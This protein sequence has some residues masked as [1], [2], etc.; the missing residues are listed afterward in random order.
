MTAGYLAR[1]FW[2]KHKRKKEEI[3]SSKEEFPIKKAVEQ[4]RKIYPEFFPTKL[5][6]KSHVEPKENEAI[7]L[8]EFPASGIMKKRTEEQPKPRRHSMQGSSTKFPLWS[9]GCQGFRKLFSVTKAREPVQKTQYCKGMRKLSHSVPI[10]AQG[11]SHE[12]KKEEQPDCE[13]TR[14]ELGL[15]YVFFRPNNNKF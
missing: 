10:L 14:A 5:E 8:D 1:T 7:E 13:R 4:A 15:L 2:R 3:I 6:T 11:C 9:K 12:K